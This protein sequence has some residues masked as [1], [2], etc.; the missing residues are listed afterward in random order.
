MHR[1]Q[2]VREAIQNQYGY[3]YGQ[4]IQKQSLKKFS[5]AQLRDSVHKAFDALNELGRNPDN[6]CNQCHSGASQTNQYSQAQGIEK[7]KGPL[8]PSGY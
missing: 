7:H 2:Q 5:L 4:G 3:W 1:P 6:S 8:S